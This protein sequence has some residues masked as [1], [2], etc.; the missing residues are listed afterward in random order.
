MRLLALVL[1]IVGLATNAEAQISV[2]NT[3]VAGTTITAATM[4]ANFDAI[5]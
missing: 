4:N 3:F 5:E 1:M 2:P